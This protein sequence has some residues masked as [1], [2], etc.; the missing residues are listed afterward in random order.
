M[1]LPIAKSIYD[2]SG[3]HSGVIQT[4]IYLNYLSQ[5][6]TEIVKEGG[7]AISLHHIDGTRYLQIPAVL[8]SSERA[9]PDAKEQ[10]RL[11]QELLEKSNHH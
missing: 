10:D 9:S 1:D 6:Y 11:N 7:A 3:Q 5:F 2:A 8:E 4:D